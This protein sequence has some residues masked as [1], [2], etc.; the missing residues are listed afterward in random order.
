MSVKKNLCYQKYM[1]NMILCSFEAKNNGNFK[2]KHL[3]L[4]KY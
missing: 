2:N 1:L 3:I 4:F